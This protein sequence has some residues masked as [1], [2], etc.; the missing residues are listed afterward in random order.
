MEDFF[1][2]SANVAFERLDAA[3]LPLEAAQRCYASMLIIMGK[4]LRKI[5]SSVESA[6]F[7]NTCCIGAVRRARRR[8]S[9]Y[10]KAFF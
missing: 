7:F 2:P 3:F 8:R 9:P 10:K 1:V 6:A 4:A 5:P